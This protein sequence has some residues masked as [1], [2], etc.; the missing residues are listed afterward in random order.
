MLEGKSPLQFKRAVFLMENAYLNNTLNYDQ[1]NT[2]I[3][4]IAIKL[5]SL[6]EEKHIESYRTAANWAAF[7]YME[8]SIPANEYRPYTYDFQHFISTKDPEIGF[9]SKLLK[10]KKGNCNS[11]PFLY[12]ILTEECGASASLALAPFHCFIKHKD[13][14]GNWI[15]LEMTSGSFARDAWIMQQTGV[16]VEQVSSGIYMNAL[17]Q[18][19]SLALVLKDLAANYQMQFGT[20][21]FDE[22][23]IET[24]LRYYPTGIYLYLV[25]F[26]HYRVKLLGARKQ[27]Q[28]KSEEAFK[29]ELSLI[30]R[31]LSELGY[32]EPSKK[33]YE[34]WVRENEK[35]KTVTKK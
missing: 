20:D 17:T 23:V 21:E 13:E 18:K 1:F 31:Q 14:K 34:G 8:D 9:V 11:L 22:K 12:K 2:E 28:P 6:I 26:E 29:K 10:T 4:S 19:Q 27:K 25:K 16:T 5:R 32:R 24:G 30:E 15:N 35:Q 33:E 3:S 7:T